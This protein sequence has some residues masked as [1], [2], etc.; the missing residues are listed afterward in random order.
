MHKVI[1]ILTASLLRSFPTQFIMN[2]F[3]CVGKQF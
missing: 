2:F 1:N 3:L